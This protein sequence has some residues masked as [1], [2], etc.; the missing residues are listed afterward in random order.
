MATWEGKNITRARGTM[1]KPG[2]V[3]WVRSDDYPEFYIDIKAIG[4]RL[5]IQVWD[6]KGELLGAAEVKQLYPRW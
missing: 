6:H 4:E 3:E 1:L 5:I 2:V